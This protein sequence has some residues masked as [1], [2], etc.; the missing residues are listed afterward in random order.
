M[1][2]LYYRAWASG[3]NLLARYKESNLDFWGSFV[4]IFAHFCWWNH[5]ISES[6]SRDRRPHYDISHYMS[7][8][9][10]LLNHK[11]YGKGMTL[12]QQIPPLFTFSEYLISSPLYPSSYCL[13]PCRQAARL[14]SVENQAVMCVSPCSTWL[15]HPVSH[16]LIY[17]LGFSVLSLAFIYI[18]SLSVFCV[19]RCYYVNWWAEAENWSH[20]KISEKRP[21]FRRWFAWSESL[22]FCPKLCGN[23]R[24]GQ[25]QRDRTSTASI[26]AISWVYGNIFSTFFSSSRDF[27][28]VLKEEL[29]SP[30]TFH[31]SIYI[32]PHSQT[33]LQFLRFLPYYHGNLLITIEAC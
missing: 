28:K 25:V 29:I 26:G 16:S 27:G 33:G 19:C 11:N 1:S 10:Y 7:F 17:R 31:W 3:K 8:R 13:T 30:K 2:K 14:H 9:Q 32:H 4:T 22:H 20:W 23:A 6:I 12:E 24:S 15:P 5:L 18:T 21:S